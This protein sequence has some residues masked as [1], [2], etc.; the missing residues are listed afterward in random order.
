MAA[1]MLSVMDKAGLE[2]TLL[3][4]FVLACQAPRLAD[5]ARHLGQS[6]PALSMA[7]HGLE[8]KL[9]LK[10]FVR[11]AGGLD[12]LPSAFWL[13]R[14][15]AQLLYLEELARRARPAKRIR[16][17]KL[18]VDLD[19]NFAIG[20]VSKALL[21]TCRELIST[22]PELAVEWRFS[23]LDSDDAGDPS[24][25][26]APEALP[27]EHGFIRVF[28]GNRTSL[29]SS[30]TL[31][32]EDPWIV[33]GSPGSRVGA[34]AESDQLTMLR[35]RPEITE[36]MMG[37]AHGRGFA[38]QIQFRDEEPAQLADILREH[39]HLRLLMPSN[40]LPI[41]LGLAR[42]EEVPFNPRFVSSLYGQVSGAAADHGQFFLTT[43]QRQLT[44]EGIASFT[45]RLNTRQIHYFN[46][47]V[48]TGSIS[49]AARVA[50]SAQ[51]SVSKHI[52]QMEDVMGGPLLR[53]TE[54]GATL[55]PLGDSLRPLTAAIEERQDW[56]IRKARDIA[57]HSEARV[58]I[59]TLPS[60][61]H[62][63][64]LTE[65]I[66]E[67]VTRI[68]ARHPDWQLQVVEAS[69]TVLHER[70]RAG[71]LNLAV[72]G[73]VNTQVARIRLGPME[74]LS[75]I[76]NPAINLAG[77]KDLRLEDVVTLPLVLGRHHLSIHQSFAE[78]AR[79]RSLRINPVV[80]VGSL[81]LAIAMVR[82]APLCTVL[83]ASSVRQDV[84][85]GNL[86]VVPIRQDELS[87]ALSLIFSAERELSEAERTIVQEF[88]RV[89]RPGHQAEPVDLGQA[90]EKTI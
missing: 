88:T 46:L 78:A 64:A 53:R 4:K 24:G 2:L 59:G 43:L 12:L 83:P 68:H 26:T 47:A 28:Y 20:R 1:P 79:L 54:E 21:R 7:L 14:V 33:V 75:V 65:R 58:T 35:M 70:V 13:F 11:R 73:V 62:D 17:V 52:T 61:G 89:F 69:N 67:V 49:A 5:A 63:S 25:L 71:D 27:G 86:Q 9:G 60:S 48:H 45:P 16:P 6:A 37:F 15:G 40:L 85:L 22:H 81:A 42:H 55:S 44:E 80:E 23:G 32:Y 18:T 66:A 77:R 30:A 31:L 50:N 90:S 10:L 36:V 57:A 87:G 39:P 19:L 76:C 34:T 82:K 51:S 84:A 41:R 56:I 74:S 72:V 8:D 38:H 29:P 3:S